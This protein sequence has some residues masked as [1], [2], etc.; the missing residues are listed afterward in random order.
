[1][2]WVV[3]NFLMAGRTP[4]P[5]GNDNFTASPSG[6]FQTGNGPINIAAN[7][8][9]QFEAVCRAAGRSDLIADPRFARRQDRLAN[10]AAL[11]A[12]LEAAFA[13]KSAAEW[14]A[15]L[16]AAG[17]PAGEVFSVPDILAHPQIAERGMIGGF[18]DAPGVGRDVKLA[19]TGIKLDGEAPS[20]ATPPPELGADTGAV[21]AELG[22]D[23]VTIAKLR[24][25]GAI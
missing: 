3:S 1:M 21:L 23:E 8:Q 25:D 11:T 6:T 13:G 4:V 16:N 10:R 22:Y 19:R 20:T 15:D 12:E 17:V 14:R 9:E 18:A 7:K 24:S 2:G 5:M